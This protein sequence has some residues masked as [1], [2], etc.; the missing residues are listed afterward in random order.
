MS[1]SIEEGLDT[2]DEGVVPMDVRPPVWVL[3]QVRS[4]CKVAARLP[5]RWRLVRSDLLWSDVRR[6]WEGCELRLLGSGS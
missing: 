5:H 4:V 1:F 3:A 6:G 2:V